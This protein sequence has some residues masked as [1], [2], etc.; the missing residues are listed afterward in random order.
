MEAAS[1]DGAQGIRG[2]ARVEAGVPERFAGVDIADAGD[3]SLVEQKILEGTLRRSQEL[4]ES[5]GGEIAGNGIQTQT[6]ESGT[7]PFRFPG[8]NSAEMARVGKTENATVQFEG[9]IDMDA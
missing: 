4:G 9:N 1:F 6:G 5:G 3:T 2:A 8:L 7:G